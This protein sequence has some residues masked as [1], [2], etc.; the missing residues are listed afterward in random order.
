MNATNAA[1]T[2]T[3]TDRIAELRETIR[4]LAREGSHVY[5]GTNTAAGPGCATGKIAS[6]E[7]KVLVL[8]VCANARVILALTDLTGIERI[9]P[10]KE[11]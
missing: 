10:S 11:K 5:V 2:N 4:A 9:P 3:S 6:L 1:A 7:A 8:T